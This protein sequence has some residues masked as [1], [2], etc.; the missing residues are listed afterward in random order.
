MHKL[1]LSKLAVAASIVV[2]GTALQ[3]KAQDRP[4]PSWLTS[5]ERAAGGPI[6]GDLSLIE[7]ELAI[8]ASVTSPGYYPSLN[9]AE[10]ADSARSGFF[11]A[12][13]FTGSFDGPNQVYAW[14][15]EDSYQGLTYMVNR[16]PG[17]LYLV[18]GDYPPA[19]GPMPPGPYIAKADATTGK[20]I[21]RTYVDNANVTGRWIGNANLNIL[22][23]GRIVFAW[24]NQ[25][26]LI[27]ADTGLILKH[28]TL[29]AG[30]TPIADVNF[31]HL[32][33]APDRTLILKDQT[34]P[35]GEKGQG[36]MAIIRGVMAGLK[37]G[38][39]HLVAVHPDTLDVLHDIPLP[40]PATA[41]HIVTTIDDRIAIY[42]PTVTG[43]IRCFWDPS[44]KRLSQDETWVM[45]PMKPGQGTATAPT[46]IGDWVAVQ[47][48]GAPSDKV[49]S[50]IAVAHRKDA[51]R[52]HVIFPFGE[53]KPGEWSFAPP[54]PGGDPE[55]SMLYSADAGM[56][57]VAGVRID[58]ETGELELAFVVDNATTTFQ[59]VIGPKDRRVLL[60][61]NMK[62][63]DPA[64][65]TQLALFSGNY[66]EQ[67]TWRDAAT[68]RILAES[69]FFEPITINSLT[70]PG[71]G[72]RVYFPTIK[73]FI[74]LQALPRKDS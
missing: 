71:F 18:G 32:T 19:T 50:S 3:L 31:K 65:P 40:E 15:S 41:P 61:T 27:D 2:A 4:V 6:P 13:S 74:V 60:L 36:T 20:Q 64:Q 21:W 53:L 28:N 17:E 58:Q 25:I 26:I 9:A 33:I 44:A 68:G 51:S 66:R 22:D 45:Q 63:N 54:K 1:N 47:T 30:D 56:G 10:I 49:A 14:R 69:D 62:K 38:N 46:L 23:N 48:N 8:A 29:P 57:K 24:S 34:R 72:G 59:P 12:A 73:E 11:P 52:M 5:N 43:V 39:S 37:Q 67:L 16:R 42:V 55:N 35:T 7:Q 70:V